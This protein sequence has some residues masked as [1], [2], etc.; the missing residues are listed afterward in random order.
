MTTA[1]VS[2]DIFGYVRGVLASRGI[3]DYS[4]DVYRW[5]IPAGRRHHNTG[6]ERALYYLL[7]QPLPAGAVLIS[8]TWALRV[9]AQWSSAGM[10]QIQEFSGQLSLRLPAGAT[11]EELTFLRVRER[12][13]KQEA[14][15]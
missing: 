6:G 4:L 2:V 9:G 14:R 7:P 15:A 8:D 1:T 11:V 5:V 12:G 3:T 10:G 13:Q